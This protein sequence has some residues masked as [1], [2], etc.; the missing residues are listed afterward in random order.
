MASRT[1][2]SAATGRT[3]SKSADFREEIT[4][5]IITALETGTAPWQ[6]PW[7]GAEGPQNG[8]TH[9]LYSGINTVILAL[10]MMTMDGDKKRDPR[11]ITF[12][13]AKGNNWYVRKNERGT[14][15]LLWRPTIGID[16]NGNREIT[17]V[18]QRTFTVFHAS[19]IEG[20]PDYVPPKLNIIEA[21]EKAERIIDASGAKVNFG[22]GEA[23]YSPSDDY[24]QMPPKTDF[25]TAE[26]YYS[27]FF[28]ELN[29]WTG[30]EKRLN[31]VQRCGKFSADYAFEELIAEMGSL[32]IASS[33][34]IPQSETEFQNHASY[35]D[36]W[37]SSLRNDNMYI[38][39]AAAEASKAAG[40]LLRRAG[41]AGGSDDEG[42]EV[43]DGTQPDKADDDADGA[44]NQD[45]NQHE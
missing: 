22:G 6:Q 43:T 45:G 12:N 11:W 20:I 25:R 13:Q 44:G 2:R 30:G 35:I 8:I 17:S 40:Y 3:G 38:F 34:G 23:F 36:G 15:V 26:G 29:H 39:K 21:H 18:L 41:M 4:A 32:F 33:A 24:I 28:H 7:N 37:L 19:Q 42:T 27:T 9:H 5:K 10:A 14:K 16:E 1:S 31:R